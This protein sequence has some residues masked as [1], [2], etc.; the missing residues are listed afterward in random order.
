[1]IE[2]ADMSVIIVDDAPNMCKSIRGMMKVLQ[3][4]K[5]FRFAN[6]GL[7][8]WSILKKEKMDLAIIDW[9]MPVMTGVELLSRIR[10]D[11]D[12]RDLPVIMVTAEA[13]RE[14]VAEAAE[15]DIDAYILKPLTVK[16]LGDRILAVVEQ[17]NNPPPAVLHLKNARV[18][19][20]AGQIELAIEEAKMAIK[21]D[22]KS[23][24][25]V[26]EL[27]YYYFKNGDMASAEKYL[28][29]AA[30]MN[31]LDVFAFHNLGE[32]YL[33]KGEIQKAATFFDKA[34]TISPRH[35][36]RGIDFGKVLIRKGMIKKAMEVFNKVFDIS[37]DPYT[38]REQI[39]DYCLERGV[40]NFA[41]KLL[42]TVLLRQP[43]RHDLMF[44][45][46]LAYEAVGS[47]NKALGFLVEADKLDGKNVAVKLH[48][49]KNYMALDKLLRADHILRAVI[50]L[51]PENADAREMLKKCVY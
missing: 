4:G 27:G 26:R 33:Q 12:M 41:A 40:Y 48:I 43:K 39:A 47:N 19:E 38:L 42:E 29:A 1:M 20:D 3:L 13:N 9:N 23:S 30:Q 2:P 8:A 7:E 46:G 21:A 50:K 36:T 11:R 44:K 49:A 10:E 45:C 32:L 18:H 37:D 35:V 16:S 17:A 51:E 34:M 5:N 22:P 14:I 6:H 31:D 24:K 25:P 15:S 28:L